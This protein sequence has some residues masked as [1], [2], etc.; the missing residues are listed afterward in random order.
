MDWLND[1]EAGTLFLACLF[2]SCPC[3]HSFI[4]LHHQIVKYWPERGKSGF[5]V[6]R[7]QFR[8]DDPSPAPWTKAGKK[9][10]Q[11][12]GLEMEVCN[13]EHFCII[14]SSGP[15]VT[16]ITW[17]KVALNYQTIFHQGNKLQRYVSTKH[18]QN[19]IEKFVLHTYLMKSNLILKFVHV[20]SWKE[21][22]GGKWVPQL[23]RPWYVGRL[24]EI[25]VGLG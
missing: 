24:M 1:K 17:W 25:C 9:K 6:W 14:K 15:D 20:G 10:S 8:R 12:L 11:D 16:I 4:P 22:V 21:Y 19:K 2:F 3:F 23:R 5:L 7:Y 13:H 18:I